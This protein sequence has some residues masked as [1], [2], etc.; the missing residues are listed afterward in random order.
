ML[1]KLKQEKKHLTFLCKKWRE[2][3]LFFVMTI[4]LTVQYLDCPSGGVEGGALAAVAM[5][6]LLP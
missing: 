1:H 2:K 3:N 6:G 5:A 4:F